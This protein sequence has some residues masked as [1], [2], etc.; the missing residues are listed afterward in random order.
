MFH[1]QDQETINIRIQ[2]TVKVIIKLILLPHFFLE[3]F[4]FNDNHFVFRL[5]TNLYQLILVPYK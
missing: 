2:I 1:G 4:S 5:I 3:I